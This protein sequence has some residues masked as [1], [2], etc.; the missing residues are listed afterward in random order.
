MLYILSY[1]NRTERHEETITRECRVY[2]FDAGDDE[3]ARHKANVFLKNG[4]K[5]FRRSGGHRVEISLAPRLFSP[6]PMYMLPAMY[7]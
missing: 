1:V 2:I 7:V 6:R 5:L 3:E 4:R